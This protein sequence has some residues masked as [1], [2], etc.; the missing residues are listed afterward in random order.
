[1]N[2]TDFIKVVSK[3]SLHCNVNG[4]VEE[5]RITKSQAGEIFDMIFGEDGFIQVGLKSDGEVRLPS[6]G[7]LYVVDVEER[8]RCNPQNGEPLTVPAHK[9]VRFK[10]SSVLKFAINE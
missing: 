10:P 7:K 4:K 2:K 3:E 5:K 6:F 1:M 8:Q 9:A